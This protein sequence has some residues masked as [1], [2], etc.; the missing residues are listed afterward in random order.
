MEICAELGVPYH[1]LM[2]LAKRLR[3]RGEVTPESKEGKL[4]WS[5]ADFERLRLRLSEWN[6]REAKASNLQGSTTAEVAARVGLTERQVLAL[7]HGHGIEVARR[8]RFL[9]WEETA[10]ARLR[11]ILDQKGAAHLTGNQVAKRLK[12]SYQ[13]LYRLVQENNV[14]LSREGNQILWDEAAVSAVAE[15]VRQLEIRRA[16]ER[17]LIEAQADFKE[18]GT[19]AVCRKLGIDYATLLSLIHPFRKDLKLSRRG[20]LLVWTPEAVARVEEALKARG[21]KA[22]D[23]LLSQFEQLKL[24]LKKQ[25]NELEETTK[26]L[27][28]P[29]AITSFISALPGASHV[30][31]FPVAVLV[32]TLRGAFRAVL[33]DIELEAI[34]PTPHKAILN[35]R[36]V[37]WSKYCESRKAPNDS[38]EAQIL[39]QLI[40]PI[41]QG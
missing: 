27:S 3:E 4:L 32:Y 5:D 35:L 28:T 26:E 37:L 13:T 12:I 17:R 33:I 36:N 19:M 30:L 22:D 15:L 8:G 39:A 14:P 34:G 29:P 11:A 6:E 18:L 2:T 24:K 16:S 9:A 25:L 7:M 10:I 40:V 23:R 21:Q 1:Q 20:R 41:E 31:P 38:P